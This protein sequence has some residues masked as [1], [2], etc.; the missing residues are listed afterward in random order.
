MLE[1]TRNHKVFFIISTLVLF[2]SFA[3]DAFG[4]M[5]TASFLQNFKDSEALVSNDITC[6]GRYFD[7]Q[8]LAPKDANNF[9]AQAECQPEK[10]NPYS[11]QFGLQ[12]RIYVLGYNLISAIHKMKPHRYI[13]VAQLATALL[14]AVAFALLAL[15]ARRRF[16]LIT[17]GTVTFFCAISPMVVGFGR[18]LY[19][20]L[21][22]MVAPLIYVLFVYKPKSSWRWQFS[23][24]SGLAI[25]LYL[26]FL[27][28]YE[29]VT[30]LTIMAAAAVAYFLFLESASLKKYIR[31]FALVFLAAMF[32]FTA[33]LGTHI[34]SLSH[35]AGSPAK[36]V[37]IIKSRATERTLN[38]RGYLSYPYTGLKTNLSDLYEITDS[39]VGLNAKSSSSSQI[40]S[41]AVSLINY[42]F[43]PVFNLPIALNQPFATFAQ[44]LAA[45]MLILAALY[46]TRTKW[47]TRTD[48]KQVKALGVAAAVGLA[49]FFSWLILA[50]AH[51]LVHPHINGI[52]L[53]L[54]FAIFGYIIIG[55][56]VSRA[57]HRITSKLRA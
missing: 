32:G 16:G 18:N 11:S 8:L 24:W 10:L 36:A 50:H 13:V 42:A 17:G 12:G 35:S 3:F 46:A 44:S 22:L 30:S 37:Q 56:F 31:E 25:L 9:T 40:M 39:Y 23:F 47:A 51:S 55:L 5:S 45:F 1:T 26:R 29:Y 14:S 28:G 48:L 38:S 27:C 52:L 54:P 20:A 21:P 7:G 49:G 41:T 19:W 6:E 53:Y 4:A 2:S 43:L 57:Y 15:W 33:A 34:L